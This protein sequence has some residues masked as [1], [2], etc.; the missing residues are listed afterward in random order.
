SRDLQFRRLRRHSRAGSGFQL[1]LLA[2]R[3]GAGKLALLLLPRFFSFLGELLG[4]APR[5]LLGLRLQAKPLGPRLGALLLALLLA[6]V[7]LAADRL[8]IGLEVIGP[9]IVVDLF[10]RLDGLDGADVDLALAWANIGLR[11]R[12]AAVVDVARDVLAHRAVDG[13]AVAE[14]EQVLV[15]DVVF[16][17][18]GIQQRPEIADDPGAFLDPS[19]GEKAQSGAGT[20]DTI[21]FFRGNRGHDRLKN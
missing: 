3:L 12:L 6:G 7:A 11:V 4:L 16:F 18:L 19:G 17:L 21:G 14:L 9:V 8:Q 20:A 13:P 1:R 5:L 10:A 15:L 2:L